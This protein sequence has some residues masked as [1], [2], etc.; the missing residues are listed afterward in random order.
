[1]TK[2]ASNFYIVAGL[3]ALTIEDC[4]SM[5]YSLISQAVN[6]AARK[7]LKR[8]CVIGDSEVGIANHTQT[9][10]DC[11]GPSWSHSNWQETETATIKLTVL[12]DWSVPT[13]FNKK[14]TVYEE[15]FSYGHWVTEIRKN[16]QTLKF[17]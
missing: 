5:S 10:Y 8:G 4:S 12:G 15:I 6:Q 1:M 14:V 11:N 17:S 13:N 2:S 3:F 16:K 9:V 7:L